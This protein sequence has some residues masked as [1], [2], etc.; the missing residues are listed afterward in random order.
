MPK[1]SGFESHIQFASTC[2]EESFFFFFTHV[3]KVIEL[4]LTECPVWKSHQFLDIVSVSALALEF[5]LEMLRNEL[6]F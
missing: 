3:Q 1:R 4:S 5:R 2:L 6:Y